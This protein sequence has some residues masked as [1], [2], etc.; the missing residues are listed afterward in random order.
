MKYILKWLLYVVV[1]VFAYNMFFGSSGSSSS[2]A[3]NETLKNITKDE[4]IFN[5]TSILIKSDLIDSA[6]TLKQVLLDSFPNSEFN[7]LLNDKLK[8]WEKNKKIREQSKRKLKSLRKK[9]DD[10]KEMCF[11]RHPNSPAYSNMNGFYVYF[12]SNKDGSKFFSPRLKIQ[13]YSD[14]WL[15]IDDIELLVDGEK[16]SLFLT[17]RWQR[18]ND[19]GKIWETIDHNILDHEIE[20]LKEI[21]NSKETKMRFNGSKYFKDKT[22]TSKQKQAINEMIEIYEGVS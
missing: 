9:C 16:R 10:F 18:D 1:A 6:K 7:T 3:N 12:G 15:F 20:I 5:Q 11:Y 13:Y 4:L 19:A 14:N 21:A 22:I 8:S 17:E 2:E